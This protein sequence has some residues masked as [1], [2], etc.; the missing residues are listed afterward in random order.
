MN[1]QLDSN[2]LL[3]AKY[4][5]NYL[6]GR[7]NLLLVIIFT[8]ISMVTYYLDGSYFYFSAYVP[9]IVFAVF[10]DYSW[11]AGGDTEFAEYLGYDAE[12]VE[13][14]QT[15]GAGTWLIIGA[16]IGLLMLSVYFVCWLLSKKHPAALTVTAV[17]F[18]L[19]CALILLNFSVTAILDILFHAWVMYYLINA[20]ISNNKLNKLPPPVVEATATEVNEPM[21]VEE[22]SQINTSDINNSEKN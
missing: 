13:T 10:A 11:I 7:N 6:A 22:W 19:D 4:S 17:L 20:I 2:G 12:F 8:V 18:G 21:S 15:V 14:L 3:R 9:M 1:V 5:K 16:V